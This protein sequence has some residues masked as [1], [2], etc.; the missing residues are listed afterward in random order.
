MAN[1]WKPSYGSEHSTF[2]SNISTILYGIE[3][4]HHRSTHSSSFFIVM[5]ECFV[6]RIVKDSGTY[7]CY[8]CFAVQ[9]KEFNLILGR[10]RFFFVV[11]NVFRIGRQFA[12]FIIPIQM[13]QCLV[14]GLWDI[15]IIYDYIFD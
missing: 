1:L 3:I 14:Y 13:E 2:E 6:R 10:Y 8:N 15:N 12:K 5:H 9:V 7:I 4:C 11:K